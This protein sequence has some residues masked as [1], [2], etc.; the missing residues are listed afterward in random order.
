[1]WGTSTIFQLKSAASLRRQ[2]ADPKAANEGVLE[3]RARAARRVVPD[4]FAN[5]FIMTNS[6]AFGK[7]AEAIKS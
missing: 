1:M 3:Q 7:M 4:A 2:L 5:V 6:P